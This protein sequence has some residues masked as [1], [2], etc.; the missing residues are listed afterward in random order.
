MILVSRGLYSVIALGA[1]RLWWAVNQDDDVWLSM[2]GTR[3]QQ[4]CLHCRLLNSAF[5]FGYSCEQA[6][7]RIR[8]WQQSWEIVPTSNVVC[9]ACGCGDNTIGHWT[10]WC[11]VPLIVALSIL[12]PARQVDNLGQLARMGVKYA[13]TFFCWRLLGLIPGGAPFSQLSRGVKDAMV[14]ST[15]LVK[16]HFDKNMQ[17][18]PIE[19]T[20]RRE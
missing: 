11:P 9:R 1:T 17:K 4:K 15:K 5:P 10:R 20:L 6:I 8:E 7:D 14:V 3:H 16:C 18:R 19:T 12:R 13:V 2:R